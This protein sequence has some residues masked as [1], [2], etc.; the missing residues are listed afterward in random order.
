MTSGKLQAEINVTP[1]IDV[2][3]VLLV[4]FMLVAPATNRVLGAGLPQPARPED[5]P[6]AVLVVTVE[7]H[8]FRLG[9]RP[10]ADAVALENAL[11]EKLAARQDRTVLV[12]VEGEVRYA[13][14]V[15]AL[16]AARGAG[17]A[18]L[19]VVTTPALSS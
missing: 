4:V 5:E 16:D 14:V 8:L 10:L 9:H 15:S 19:A 11:R 17:A 2:M 13:R 18:R 7:A 6:P 3:L 1:L 12:R